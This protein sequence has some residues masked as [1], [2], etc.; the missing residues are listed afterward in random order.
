MKHPFRILAFLF[1]G[2]LPV[3]ASATSAARLDFAHGE[4]RALSPLGQIRQLAK[5][6]E[7]QS[8]ETVQTGRDGRAQLR[9]SDGGMLSLQPGSEFRLDDYRFSGQADG[10]EAGFFSLLKGGL[11]TITG[12]IGRNNRDRYKVTTSVATIGI[13]GTEYT[14]SY[15]D[16]ET[17]AVATGEGRIEVC[18]KA[19]CV[20]VSSGEAAVVRGNEEAPKLTDSR[21]RLDPAQPVT[22]DLRPP[23][24]AGE[25]QLQTMASGPG[26]TM[27]YASNVSGPA[28]QTSVTAQFNNFDLLTRAE[29]GGLSY[30]LTGG[31][32]Q[33]S[34]RDGVIGWGRWSNGVRED[35]TAIPN[36]HYAVGRLTAMSELTG[37]GAGTYT[38]S[39][40]GGS[41]PMNALGVASSLNTATMQANF[42]TGT[43]ELTLNLGVTVAG[44]SYTFTQALSPMTTS[45]TFAFTGLDDGA[46][47]TGSASGMF[48]GTNARY[49]GLSYSVKP[50]NEDEVK[51]S[52]ALGR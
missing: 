51:G 41:T 24:V 40:I 1:V 47:G 19:G 9:F 49:V 10:S 8:G 12:L 26:Y 52:A 20:L 37:L 13:R 2:L 43:M 44:N 33:A 39:L 38:Y 32:A 17:I 29:S 14:I 5:G 7:L 22:D 48:V 30:A 15:L 18:N 36:F 27:V 35:G 34:S 46:L 11:R 31:T 4:V 16:P 21:P 6:S 3:L 50:F 28:N 45:Q 42:G 25:T 23:F